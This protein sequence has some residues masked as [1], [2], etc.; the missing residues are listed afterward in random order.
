V[1]SAQ[2]PGSHRLAGA[3]LL[4]A[5]ASGAAPAQPPP[6]QPPTSVFSG[7]VPS[8]AAPGETLLLTLQDAIARGLDHNLG[9]LLAAEEVRRARATRV[10]ELG[11]LLPRLH[12]AVGE[13]SRQIN[14]DAFG[15][16]GSFPDSPSIVGPF[17]LFDARLSLQ[18]ALY[19]AAALR[20]AR[21]GAATLDAA[22]LS[23]QDARE[24]VVLAVA[25]QYLRL[26]AADRLASVV[27]AEVRT[28]E[29]LRQIAFDRKEAGTVAGIEVLRSEVRLQQD[30]HRLITVRNAQTKLRLEL[31]RMIGLPLGQEL[32]PADRMVDTAPPPPALADAVAQAW[33]RRRDLAAATARL[34]AAREA[35]RAATL[36]RV[37]ALRLAGNYG[38]LGREASTAKETFDVGATLSMP[39][40]ERGALRSDALRSE[41]EL[42]SRQAEL[43]DLRGAIYYEVQTAL[44]DLEAARQQ[45]E[46]GRAGLELAGRQL[47][48]ARNRFAAGVASNLEVVEA[49][50]AMARADESWIASLY[51]LTIERVR[52]ARAL[53]GTAEALPG[54]VTGAR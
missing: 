28:S 47:E 48:Q 45:V 13:S 37:P 40:L 32:E 42:R 12:A 10:A 16:A 5:L 27:E 35:R 1:R 53:G 33:S 50:E 21:H 51:R 46:V 29:L 25:D 20:R 15:F 14:L 22:E 34:E 24:V 9:A 36:E 39:I 54:L 4:G 11:G 30:R 41:A 8:D 31:A 43:D 3:V 19:D 49:Q 26:L 17:E 52:L 38:V 6:F 2:R 18:W 7:G 44:L 23:Y